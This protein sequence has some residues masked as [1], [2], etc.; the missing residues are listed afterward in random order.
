MTHRGG[1]RDGPEVLRLSKEAW[2]GS[3]PGG[4]GPAEAH[5]AAGCA[6]FGAGCPQTGVSHHGQHRAVCPGRAVLRGPQLPLAA[7]ARRAESVEKH[8]GGVRPGTRWCSVLPPVRCGLLPTTW[9]SAHWF[10]KK[11]KKKPREHFLKTPRPDVGL[12]CSLS[13]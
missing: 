1:I 7:G 11:K 2:R 5:S 8:C 9:D 3:S 10:S 13:G 4:A 12:C 6:S